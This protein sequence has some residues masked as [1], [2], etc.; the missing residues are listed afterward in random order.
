MSNLQK[1]LYKQILTKNVDYINGTSKEKIQ[2][3]NVLM[4]LKKVCNH[5]YLFP[6]VEPGPPFITGEH[7]IDSCMK[8]Y[9][10]DRLIEKKISQGSKMLIFSQMV[11]LINILDDYCRYRNYKFCRI[12]G[13][14]SRDDRDMMIERFQSENNNDTFIFLLSTRSGGIGINLHAAN[15][16]IIY[17]SDWNPQVDLQAIDRAHR[18]GQTKE[19]TVYRFVTEG[20]VEE[21]IIE[22]AAKK[23]KIDH[24]II[25]KGVTIQNNPSALE[26]NNM[27]HFGAKEIFS[28]EENDSTINIDID[29]LI[30]Y[31]ENKTDEITGKLKKLEEKLNISNLSLSSNPNAIYQ[32]EGED[33]KN[34]TSIEN[35][36]IATSFGVRERKFVYNDPSILSNTTKYRKP[37]ILQGWR[38]KVN[39]GYDHQ[40]F[41]VKQ[42][43]SLDEKEKRWNDYLE[44][45]QKLN[46]EI[47][48]I[49]DEVQRKILE[50]EIN[51]LITNEPDEFTNANENEREILLKKGFGKWSKKDFFRLYEALKTVEPSNLDEL[52]TKIIGKSPDQIKE[53]L[54]ALMKNINS[55]KYGIK[56]NARINELKKQKE[57]IQNYHNKIKEFYEHT[58]LINENIYNSIKLTNVQKINEENTIDL[59]LK[60]DL[61][62]KINNDKYLVCLLFKYGYGNWNNIKFHIMIDPLMRFNFDL[63]LL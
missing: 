3:L 20:T 47:A 54:E 60:E 11:M 29:Q 28:E 17:D 4:Q 2:L 14:T 40:F 53:Y 51:N 31:S 7:L 46:D 42:L 21:K 36:F 62:E 32:F 24:L 25:Q 41:N 38:A 15:T 61:E 22:R 19:V 26:L 57:V 27:I 30:K 1:K 13:S 56:I 23:L 5:P 8:L 35:N 43:D 10:L 9:I 63:K 16:V 37:R 59:M 50:D 49:E 39:G 48:L 44:K 34:Y 45:I 18:I 55:F 33:Y 52:S 6:K 12:D 58:K